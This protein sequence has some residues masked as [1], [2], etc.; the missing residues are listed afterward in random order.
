M[1]FEEHLDRLAG[2]VE[3]LAGSVVARESQIEAHD[4]RIDSLIKV[5]ERDDAKLRVPRKK[6]RP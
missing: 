5:T 3:S 4:R 6:Q 2:I 1:T